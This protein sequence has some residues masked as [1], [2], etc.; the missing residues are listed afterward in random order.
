MSNII[1]LGGGGSSSVIVSKTIT[2]N[3]TYNASADSADGY[4]PV[5]VNVS[6]GGAS[7]QI[8]YLKWRINN[9]RSNPAAAALQLSE[10]YLYLND[11]LY[12]WS[13]NVSIT[14][15]FNSISASESIEKIID[16]NVD[17]KY[18]TTQWGRSY[19]GQCVIDI[20]LGETI[21]IDENTTYA[22]VTANDEPTRDPVGWALFGSLDGSNWFALDAR[23]NASV[24]TDRKTSTDKFSITV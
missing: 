15:S 19:V 16:K 10:F 9:T 3:G 21:T 7:K 13:S 2:Q 24:P 23:D 1:K 20:S 6:G 4:N 22:Y 8:A 18:T 5:I 11:V 17:T 12:N 14:A